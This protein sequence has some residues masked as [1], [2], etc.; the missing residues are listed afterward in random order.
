MPC[1]SAIP[2]ENLYDAFGS[3][4]TH[5][6]PASNTYMRKYCQA[7]DNICEDGRDATKQSSGR[8]ALRFFCVYK[9]K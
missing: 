1:S 4:F 8:H 7:K 2:K 3:L 6:S 5:D 9:I